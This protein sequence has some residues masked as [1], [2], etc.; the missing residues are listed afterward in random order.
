MYPSGCLEPHGLGILSSIAKT[1][2]PSSLMSSAK[3]TTPK[4]GVGEKE[5]DDSK[6]I[7]KRKRTIVRRKRRKRRIVKRKRMIGRL[8][9]LPTWTSLMCTQRVTFSRRTL[10][11]HALLTCSGLC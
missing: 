6:T 1:L 9:L 7:M 3:V 4:S 2:L 10:T 11:L 5:D 8:A